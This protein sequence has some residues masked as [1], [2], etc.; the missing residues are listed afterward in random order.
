MAVIT[1]PCSDVS[2]TMLVKG[3]C[4][5]WRMPKFLCF[6]NLFQILNLLTDLKSDFVNSQ[7]PTVT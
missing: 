7:W 3:A 1:Y 2:Q 4:V 6:H 5:D